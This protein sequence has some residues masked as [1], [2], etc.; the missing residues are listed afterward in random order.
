M[1]NWMRT[2]RP[3]SFRGVT[4][5]VDEEGLPKSGRRVAT[6]E[7]VKAEEHGTEDMGRLPREFRITAYLASDV[8]DSDVQDLIDACST[9]GAATL[10]LPFFGG[11][12]VRCTGCGGKH[13]KDKLGYVGIDLEFVEAG[14]DGAVFPAIA[15]GDRIA[16]SILDGL[17]DLVS[18]ALSAFPF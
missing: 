13:R 7:Y 5:Y 8:A 10:I 4:F 18:D 15:I 12:Q 2:L 16:S 1:R 14:G 17:S 6:H 9:A 11:Q 3:A